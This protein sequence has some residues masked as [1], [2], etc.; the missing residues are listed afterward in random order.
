MFWLCQKFGV[1]KHAVTLTEEQKDSIINPIIL[2]VNVDKALSD[3]NNLPCYKWLTSLAR[4]NLH[5]DEDFGIF[6][7][8][9]IAVLQGEKKEFQLNIR[10]SLP[11]REDL[12]KKL[13]DTNRNTKQLNNEL[14]KKNKLL[15]S[16]SIGVIVLIFLAI[17]LLINSLLPVIVIVGNNTVSEYLEAKGMSLNNRHAKY[18][19]LRSDEAW[20]ALGAAVRRYN[21]K[22]Y[23]FS[24]IVLSTDTVPDPKLKEEIERH[25]SRAAVKLKILQYEIARVDL[26]LYVLDDATIKSNSVRNTCDTIEGVSLLNLLKDTN[27]YVIGPD[28]LS[29]IT[30]AFDKY[31]NDPTFKT[32]NIIREPFRKYDTS[33]LNIIRSHIG[34][35]KRIIILDNSTVESDTT[36]SKHAKKLVVSGGKMSLY[37]Y[38]LIKMVGEDNNARMEFFNGQQWFF[39]RKQMNWECLKIFHRPQ[40]RETE[41]PDTTIVIHR[42]SS[43]L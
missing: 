27:C 37:A 6:F 26:A 1:D 11:T 22:V 4:V 43:V 25:N 17:L 9:L 28:S 34:Q 8:D 19:H 10:P 21:E 13:I 7:K 36:I 24:P 15:K 39:L 20:K 38:T 12:E 29:N 5:T 31:I 18:F 3:D 33:S 30:K 35:S 14:K 42:E 16:S 32:K 23:G 41:F 2:P 40:I